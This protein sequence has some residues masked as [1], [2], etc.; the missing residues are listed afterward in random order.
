MI[1]TLGGNYVSSG[2]HKRVQR[3]SETYEGGS[4]TQRNKMD[5]VFT[6]ATHNEKQFI[7]NMERRASVSIVSQ[8]R[9]RFQ[10]C[11]QLT[12]GRRN[13]TLVLK[14]PPPHLR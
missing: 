8:Y 9:Y 7:E 3:D 2:V 6:F 4:R 1:N 5:R 11:L 14:A 10:C 12:Y 13:V